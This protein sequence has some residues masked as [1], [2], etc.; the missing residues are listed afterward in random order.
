MNLVR[1]IL[2]KFNGLYYPQEYLCL[3]KESFRYPLHAYMVSD[4]LVIKDVT[5]D[6][7]F[8]GYCPLIFT[9]T[10]DKVNFPQTERINIVFSLQQFQTNELIPE[11]DAIAILYLQKINEQGSGNESF[12]YYKGLNGQYHFISSFHQFILQLQNKLFNNKTGN[13]YLKGNLLKQV[14]IA[15]SVPRII[16]LITLRLDGLYNL[17]PT[18]LHGQINDKH[19]I[20]S[21]R[22][23]G[24][25]AQQVELTKK[26]L[27][28]EINPAFYKI[29]YSLGKNHMQDLKVKSQFPFSDKSSDVL[30]LPLPQ[31]AVCY[32][33]LELVSSFDHGIHRL[34]LF[35]I[36]GKRQIDY[37]PAVLSHIHNV[38]ATWR[39]NKGLPGNYLLR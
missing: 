2:N 31:S 39:H 6:H 4:N 13:V 25:A 15:Y 30:D 16:S 17:F 22:Q 37:K 28:S 21:L 18:D 33:E 12:H 5:T 14:Q 36:M 7:L 27:I 34:F 1:K 8:T 23:G 26:I 10:C 9:F 24:K 3:D 32:R 11:K 19:Y 35:R 29:A 38:Y 20:I